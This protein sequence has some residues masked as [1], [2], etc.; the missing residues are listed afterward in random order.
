MALKYAVRFSVM[1]QQFGS[2]RSRQESFL[3]DYQ[4]HQYRL[5]ILMAKCFSLN[6]SFQYLADNWAKNQ[7]KMMQP[8]NFKTA[9][10]HAIISVIKPITSWTAHDG[11]AICRRAC[12][13]LGYSYY[14]RFSI[15]S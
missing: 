11:I 12:G 1:R 15:Y 14:S 5:F 3:V 8:G 13:G 7:K 10:L 9:E 4:L 6:N 2:P